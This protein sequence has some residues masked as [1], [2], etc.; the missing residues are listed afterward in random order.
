MQ[1]KGIVIPLETYFGGKHA[2]TR[3]TCIPASALHCTLVVMEKLT[4]ALWSKV[5]GAFVSNVHFTR[6][7][8]ID[9]YV[10]DSHQTAIGCA[11]IIWW[12][13]GKCSN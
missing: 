3:L 7:V 11:N 4:V 12:L 6:I 9:H 8:K 13:H 5:T 2:F 10:Q 1:M